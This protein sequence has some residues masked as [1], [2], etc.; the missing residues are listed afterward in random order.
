MRTTLDAAVQLEEFTKMPNHYAAAIVVSFDRNGLSSTQQVWFT[1]SAETVAKIVD[2]HIADGGE[3]IG[4]I[5]GKWLEG[6]SVTWFYYVY[7][8]CQ[9]LEVAEHRIQQSLEEMQKG[10]VPNPG[11]EPPIRNRPAD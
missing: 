3:P 10:L 8:E 5:F 7:S 4:V 9:N 2:Q 1:E 11:E 6:Q